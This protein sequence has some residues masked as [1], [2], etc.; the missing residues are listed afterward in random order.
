MIELR[1]EDDIADYLDSSSNTLIGSV[2]KMRNSVLLFDENSRDNVLYCQEGVELVDSR[3]AFTSCDALL[4]LRGPNCNLRLSLDL[5]GGTCFAFGASGY[6][7]GALHVIVSERTSVIIGDSALISFGV[8][9]RTADPHLL[10]SAETLQRV[11]PSKDILIGDH[12]WLGQDCMLLKGTRI[13]S[14]SVVG[15]KALVSGKAIPSNTVWGGNPARQITAGVFFDGGGC[16]HNYDSEKTKAS[17][18]YADKR[19]VYSSSCEVNDSGLSRL[20]NELRSARNAREKAEMLDRAYDDEERNRFAFDAG[21]SS[22]ERRSTP[23]KLGSL[24]RWVTRKARALG[25]R[26]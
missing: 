22:P 12:V 11:N 1:S 3:I 7:N 10:Y 9:I 5:H 14:G 2:P 19:W 23:M 17:K 13:G 24:G 6:T 16:V 4:F 21:L 18:S 26:R 8:W 15:A 20:S 25:G